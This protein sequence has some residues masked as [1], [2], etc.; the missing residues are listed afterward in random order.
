V[1]EDARKCPK[2]GGRL[3]FGIKSKGI[4]DKLNVSDKFANVMCCIE[5]LYD[6]PFAF[7]PKLPD[8]PKPTS[9]TTSN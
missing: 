2:C 9:E 7:I 6:E 4:I 8:P 5:C 1:G 3:V